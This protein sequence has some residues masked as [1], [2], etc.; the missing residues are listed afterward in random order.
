MKSYDKA[1][2]KVLIYLRKE[3][4]EYEEEGIDITKYL[5][6]YGYIILFQ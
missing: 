1:Y 5:I 3:N 4:G 2:V 6:E